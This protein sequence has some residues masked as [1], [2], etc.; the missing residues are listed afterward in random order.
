[1]LSTQLYASHIVGGDMYYDCLGGNTYRITLKIYRDCLSDGADFDPL[2]PV[3]VFDGLNIQIDHFTIPFPGSTTLDVLFENPCITLPGD[4]CVEEAIYQKTVTLPD[5]PSGYTLSYQRC[6]RGPEVVNLNDPDDEG[7]TLQIDIPPAIL[8][9]CNNSARFINYP[10]LVLCSGQEVEFDHSAID[11]DGDLL[12]YELCSPFSG[13]S[14]V[15]P[16]PDPSSPPPYDPVVWAPGISADD[17]FGDGDLTIDPVTGMVTALPEAPGLYAVGVCVNEYR[18]GNL[19]STSRRDFLFKVVNCDIELGAE[20]TPQEDLTTFVSFCQGLEI[21]FENNSFGGDFYKWDFGVP[22]IGTDVSTEFEPSYTFPSPGTYEVM[23]VVNPGWPCTDTSVETFIVANEIDASFNSPDPQC[24]IDNSFDFMGDGIYPSEGEGT[25][26]EWNF[27]GASIPLFST[28]ENP[29]DIVFIEAGPHNVTFTVNYDIC[30]ISHTEEI[31]VYAEPTINFTAPDELKCAPYTANFT[32]LSFAHT[33]IFYAWDFGDGIGTSDEANPVYIYNEVGVYDVTLVIWT[34]DGC[35]DTLTL[36]RENLIEIFPSP[37]S[38]F[39]VTPDIQDEYNADFFFTDHS[40]DGVEQW[41][42]FAD[43]DFSQET[44]V[45]HNY[46]E[47]GVYYPWQIVVNEFGCKDRS[48]Q[49]VTIIPVIPVLVPNTF[50]PDG[51]G[52]NNI[53]KPVFYDDENQIF[54]MFIYNRWGELIHETNG[55]GGYWDGAYQGNIAPDGVYIWKII[56][57]EYDTGLPTEI[58]GHVTLLK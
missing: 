50:T 28:D 16:A 20:L 29:T 31:F 35:I 12:V 39:T 19:I 5:S 44:E 1:M 37:T 32:D 17:P 10:P 57:N 47:P 43:G 46:T 22:G 51:N 13:G 34:V 33:E 48:Y 21:F 2:L 55:S 26:F 36:L 58:G 56:Y 40:I 54:H 11:P 27:G 52:V 49:Q 41:F 4:I 3:T 6:C 18:D 38:D 8:A 53:F 24:I 7:L 30:S 23:L 15:F 9:T 45:W 25:T 42:Y 14:S